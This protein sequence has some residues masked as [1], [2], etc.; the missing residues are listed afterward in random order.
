M[1]VPRQ[2]VAGAALG[3]RVYVVGGVAAG[4]P[5]PSAVVETYD[6]IADRWSLVASLPFP[7]RG[8]AAAATAPFPA[9]KP[10]TA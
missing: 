3:D 7:L 10:P 8:V 2:E 4:E 1:G 6:T 5:A 9:A